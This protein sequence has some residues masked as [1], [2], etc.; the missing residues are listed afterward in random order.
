MSL[1]FTIYIDP[2]T[3]VY[4]NS[5]ELIELY[6]IYGDEAMTLPTVERL[7]SNCSLSSISMTYEVLYEDAN[8]GYG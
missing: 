6:Y 2:C 3:N 8:G 5:Y 7:N 1:N 4:E